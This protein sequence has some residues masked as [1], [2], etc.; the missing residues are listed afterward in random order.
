MRRRH[1]RDARP[2]RGQLDDRLESWK[3]IATY[4]GKDVRTVQRWENRA[5][6]PVH[7]HSEG[8]VL[9]VCA[10][11]SELDA[12][13]RQDRA[14]PANGTTGAAD[15]RDDGVLSDLDGE[16]TPVS[17]RPASRRWQLSWVA[18]A[19]LTV[20]V[21]GAAWVIQTRQHVPDRSTEN[22]LLF[23]QDD[24]VLITQFDN[25]TG[26]PRFDGKGTLEAV[27]ELALSDSGFLHVAQLER[28]EDALR[29]MKRPLD[30]VIDRTIGREVALRDGGIRAVLAGSIETSGAGYVLTVQL[31]NPQDGRVLGSVREAASSDDAGLTLAIRRQASRVRERLGEALP[32]IQASEQRLQKVTTPSLRA[33][34][35]YSQGY[36]LFRI[37]GPAQKPASEVLF[38]EAIAEDGSFA[39]AY[40]MLGWAVRRD[41]QEEALRHWERAVELASG[42]PARD[43]LFIEGTYLHWTEHTEEAIA[44]YEALLEI[45]PDHY[46]ARNNLN[47][48]YSA[49]GRQPSGGFSARQADL[50]P[51][52]ARSQVSAARDLIRVGRVADARV[53]VERA[54]VLLAIEALDERPADSAFV[55][56]FPAYEH[57]LHGE[58]DEVFRDVETLTGGIPSLPTDRAQQTYSFQAATFYLALGRLE[59]ARELFAQGQSATLMLPWLA[60]CLDDFEALRGYWSALRT[61]GGSGWPQRLL[62]T[63]R[64]GLPLEPEDVEAA[65]AFQRDL[66]FGELALRR[67]DWHQAIE[68]LQQ[69]VDG[70]SRGRLEYYLG[71]E[72]LATAFQHVGDDAQALRVLE[73][74]AAAKA[75]YDSSFWGAFG[76]LRVRARL[77]REYRT[78]GR[79]DE[80]VAIEDDVLH[81][82]KYADAD[83]PI[84]LQIREVRT[85]LVALD[86]AADR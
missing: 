39:A 21:L 55:A 79:I 27:L 49:L 80:A 66:A 73:A 11:R 2:G 83:H 20:T 37:P 18:G 42:A 68:L 1:D 54:S 85:N 60:D 84:V 76:G 5:G 52:V 33:L 45:H 61:A 51:N 13:Q 38:R 12:W 86:L 9:N 8:S 82:L 78:L 30:S 46:Y 57:W 31:V 15:G 36:A 81:M 65:P 53:Y 19:V 72:S 32:L 75:R 14:L 62:R 56:L 23:G 47:G 10:Y 63:V 43:R 17:G 24:Y 4:L 40:N 41:D 74:A 6:L 70:E 59:R 34:Q 3:E 7:R 50:R 25:L 58:I 44:K 48:L 16:S 22:G 71:A 26:E 29:L 77:A 28:I 64:A 35:L 69:G 67:E